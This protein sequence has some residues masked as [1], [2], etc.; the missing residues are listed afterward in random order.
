M[1][2]FRWLILL[3]VIGL[4][5]YLKP[6]WVLAPLGRYLVNDEG[7]AKSDC[8][9]VLAGDGYGK[10]VLRSVELFRQGYAPK[11]LISGPHGSYD[12]TE[13]ELSIDFARRKG[14]TDVVFVGLPHYATSTVTEANAVLPKLR[15]HGCRSVLVVTSDYHTRRAGKVLRRLW[16]GIA[17]RMT[18]APAVDYDPDWWWQDRQSQKTF[19]LEWTKTF[20]DWLGI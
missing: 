11:V 6:E 5:V 17:V 12:K 18:A 16:P 15:E 4:V 8:I 9:F 14:A 20:A 13:D 2:R 7:P 1:R 10:R 19:F 3:L